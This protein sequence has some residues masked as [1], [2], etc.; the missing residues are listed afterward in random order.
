MYELSTLNPPRYEHFA[1]SPYPVNKIED[2]KPLNPLTPI[3]IYKK[4]QE[5]QARANILPQFCFRATVTSLVRIWT[6]SLIL[7]ALNLSYFTIS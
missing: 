5:I 2:F 3:H 6:E 1:P 7:K 4:N